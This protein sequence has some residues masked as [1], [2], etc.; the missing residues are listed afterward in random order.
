MG[1]LWHKSLKPVLFTKIKIF[2]EEKQLSDYFLSV[3][4]LR[5]RRIHM[6]LVFPDPDPK[7]RDTDPDPS[8]VKQ[9]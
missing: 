4:R 7:V 3:L 6:F 8:I 1:D 2:I 5:I 9:K